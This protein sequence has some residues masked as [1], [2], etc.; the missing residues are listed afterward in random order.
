MRISLSHSPTDGGGKLVKNILGHL[1]GIIFVIGITLFIPASLSLIFGEIQNALG[2]LYL[3]IIVS[4]AG[5][6]VRLPCKPSGPS[7]L[8]ATVTAAIAWLLI[9]LI[10]ALPYI[11]FADIP[12]INAYFEAMSGF[13]TTGMTLINGV[14]QLPRGLLLWRALT[15]WIG[16]A[17]IILLFL[18]FIPQSGLGVGAWHLY[19]AE[20]RE[21]RLTARIQDTVRKIWIIYASLTGICAILLWLAGFNWFDALAHSFTALSTGG[22][23]TRTSSIQAFQNPT[24]ETILVIFMIFGATNFLILLRL[25]SGRILAFVKSIEWRFMLAV[26]A[27]FSLI[28][29]GELYYGSS[30]GSILEQLRI[31]V[32]QT[33]SILT[34]TG[35]TTIDINIFSPLPKVLIIIL[36][37]FGGN[38]GSTGG[39]LKTWRIIVLGKLLWQTLM[40]ITLPPETIK[41]LKIRGQVVEEEDLMKVAGFFVAYIFLIVISTLMLTSFGFEPFSAFSAACS[42]QGN[43]GPS[44]LPISDSIPPI[45]KI[46]LIFGMWTGRLEIIPALIL[47][48]PLTWKEFA[49]LKFGK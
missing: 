28:T 48:S 11:L 34:T 9:S 38:L 17:G 40:K 29:A 37:F 49:R 46:I 36:M 39:A 21:E 5:L 24:A 44:F 4:V 45:S 20:A 18:L 43:I 26:I 23:S 47:M 33:V 3:G 15:Q 31:S 41:P 32:F 10:G 16:G 35:Y 22:F 30:N 14:E 12:L 25:F 6:A 19:R 2:F 42:A 27:I 8:E 1:A 13:T 7:I